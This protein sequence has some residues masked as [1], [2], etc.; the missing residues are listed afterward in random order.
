MKLKIIILTVILSA[1]L[2]YA[3]DILDS[4]TAA[5]DGKNITLAWRTTDE[6]N[7]KNYE[8]ERSASNQYFKSI[9]IIT[10][11]GYGYNYNYIDESAFLRDGDSPQPLAKSTYKYRLKINN[12]D[13]S[14]YYSNTALVAHNVSGIRRTWGMI[15]EMFR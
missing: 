6:S 15:K 5:S 2:L 10:A 11:K 12:K 13:N 14:T 4:F 7:V 8:I 9:T 1:S 3:A